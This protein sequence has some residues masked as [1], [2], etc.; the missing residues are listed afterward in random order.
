MS[1]VVVGAGGQLGQE[2]CQLI[3]RSK[4]VALTHQ[5]IE[6]TDG[7]GFMS[8]LGPLSPSVVL[9]A[10]AFNHVDQA[11]D[12]PAD[13]FGTNAFGVRELA[14]VCRELDATLVQYSS[15]YVFGLDQN[16]D[17]SYD[18][19]AV[20]GPLGVYGLS[21]LAGEYFV[22]SICSRYFV[23][24]TCGVYGMKGAGGKGRN[25]VL[26]MLRLA[27]ENRQIRV[28]NDQTC[29]PTCAADLARAT[30]QLLTTNEY[31]LYHWTNSGSCTWFQ[32]AGEIFR[33]TGLHVDC[34]E[35]TSQVFA[36]R[37]KR[38][39]YSVLS[40]DKFQRL[41]FAMPRP[42]QDAVGEFLQQA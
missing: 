9:N 28:V 38:P 17:Q 27:R 1:I 11:E 39:G 23:I 15:D 25:F 19:T 24:R 41:G 20:P 6:L 10:A 14:K 26:T 21:K 42:W 29:T 40:T 32:F 22:R 8:V 2:L 37:A 34:T 33:Q 30:L 4:L 36:A 7:P 5:D 16:R 31:G 12:R 35:I 3:P 13:A 18:E